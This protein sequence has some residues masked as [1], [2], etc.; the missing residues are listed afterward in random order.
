MAR[1]KVEVVYASREVQEVIALELAAGATIA[2]AVKASGLAHRFSG[3]DPGS[4]LTGIFGQR[5]NPDAPLKGGDRVEI[6]RPLR[7]DPKDA[8]R[9]KATARRRA[10]R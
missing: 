7:A 9:A 10:G 8:R 4:A 2:D 1:L 5:V 3:I 6:Y